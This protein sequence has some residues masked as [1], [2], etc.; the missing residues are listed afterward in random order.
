MLYVVTTVVTRG[1]VQKRHLAQSKR[2]E[3][4]DTSSNWVCSEH[5]FVMAYDSNIFV[6]VVDALAH[7]TKYA[8]MFP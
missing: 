1:S 3:I 5:R 7:T 6:C 8:S 2:L 4:D